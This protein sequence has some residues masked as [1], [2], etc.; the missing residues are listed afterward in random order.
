MTYFTDSPFERMMQQRP[1]GR[2][3]HIPVRYAADHPCNVKLPQARREKR[4]AE[5][6]K[7]PAKE[8]NQSCD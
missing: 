7:K 2:R 6:L 3:V 8:E 1:S 5:S 4:R